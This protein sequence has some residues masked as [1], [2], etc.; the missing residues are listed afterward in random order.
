MNVYFTETERED[1][2]DY[3]DRS[4]LCGHKIIEMP[5]MNAIRLRS[6]QEVKRYAGGDRKARD[7][8]IFERC[9]QFATHREY[10]RDD[11]V[12]EAVLIVLTP[13]HVALDSFPMQSIIQASIYKPQ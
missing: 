4:P 2:N 3:L 10:S 5:G 6:R 11:F 1:L 9:R 12:S 7:S 8:Q 13:L